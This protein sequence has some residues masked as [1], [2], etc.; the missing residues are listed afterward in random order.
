MERPCFAA[1]ALAG[2][3]SSELLC[4]IEQEGRGAGGYGWTSTGPVVAGTAHSFKTGSGFGMLDGMGTDHGL[5]VTY[6]P[7]SEA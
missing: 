1:W 6:P 2:C 7:R 5:R 3:W 4:L